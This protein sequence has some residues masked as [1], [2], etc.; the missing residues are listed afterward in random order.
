MPAQPSTIRSLRTHI[1]LVFGGFAA[2][3]AVVLCLLAGEGMRVRL[4]Q[5]AASSL[6][7]LA[8][9]SANILQKDLRQQSLRADV[10]ARSPELW[11]QGLDSRAVTLLL[12]RMQSISP[13]TAWID[14]T[15][16]QGEVL[17]ATS[18]LRTGSS[19]AQRN[20]FQEALRGGFI[21]EVHPAQLLPSRPSFS[22]RDEPLRLIDFSAPIYQPEGKLLGVIGI[23]VR[24]DWV[25]DAIHTL[26]QGAEARK[27]Q[28]IFIFDSRGT[29]I[30]AP[31]GVVQSH[32]DLGQ[33][34]PDVL[35]AS[36]PTPTTA[37]WQDRPEPYL[38]AAVRLPPPT[39]DNDLGWWIVARQ[40]IETAYADA[41]RVVWLSMVAGVIAGLLAAMVA[42]RLARHVSNDLKQLAHAAS[43]MRS[44]AAPIPVLHSNRE[45]FTLSQALNRMTRQLL[46]V[47]EAMQ[48]QVRQ[49]TE[50]LHAANA[51]LLRQAC[52]DPLTQL[53]NRRGFEAR[54]AQALALAQRSQRPLSALTLDI[55]F[56]KHINDRFGHDAGDLVLQRVARLLTQRARHSD[57][58]ARFGGEEFVWLLPDTDAGAAVQLAEALRQ[59]LAA[60]DAAPASTL[61]VSIGVSALRSQ[62]PSDDLPAL[63]KRSDAALYQAKSTG[64]NR[65]CCMD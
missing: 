60:M 45:V 46:S 64:R 34:M 6:L 58:V 21:S 25:R 39:E 49:R 2:T 32:A 42:W 57:I 38:S 30:F 37:V 15:N 24:W 4:Q 65:V 19:V 7:L 47:H 14:V 54:A 44:H 53:L 23:H 26:L 36:I 9:H 5:E 43:H 1:A 12:Q 3:L 13:T 62:D 22:R 61:H 48:E 59:A 18:D 20:W 11:E 31:D 51:E 27:Q 35:N 63:L 28:N 41:N 16:P 10:L 29:L 17:N 56:F 52:T 50:Q 40:P 33:P 8:H 55:D